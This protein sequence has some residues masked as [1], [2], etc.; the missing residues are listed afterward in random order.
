MKQ[1]IIL[2]L[3]FFFVTN[4]S[5]Q[6]VV[7]PKSGPTGSWRYLGT[8]SAKSSNDHDVIVVAGPY[9]FF[10]KLKFKVVDSD[11]EMR[12]ILVRYDDGGAPERIET[13]FNIPQGAESRVLELKGG[14][15]KL[16]SV[17]FWYRDKGL[18]NGKADVMLYGIK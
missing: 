7:K 14:K 1:L 10:R 9:D 8:T 5:A 4:A 3:C 2:T 13:A 15:R 16:K 12:Y 6:K 11:I 18:F 17:E